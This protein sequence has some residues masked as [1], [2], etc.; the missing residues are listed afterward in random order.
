[1]ENLR[2]IRIF[3][4]LFNINTYKKLQ[5]ISTPTISFWTYVLI[6]PCILILISFFKKILEAL[7]FLFYVADV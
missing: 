6:L 3:K 4:L 5:N 2:W 1:M 7:L